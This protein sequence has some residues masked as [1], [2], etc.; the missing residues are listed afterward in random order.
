VLTLDNPAIPGTSNIITIHGVKFQDWSYGI[1]EDD[2]VLEKVKFMA[3]WISVED[4]GG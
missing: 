4:K 1:P 3:L 2:F